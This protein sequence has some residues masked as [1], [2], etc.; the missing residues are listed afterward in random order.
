[1][2]RRPCWTLTLAALGGLAFGPPGPAAADDERARV[3]RVFAAYDKPDSPGCVVGVIRDG[4]LVD[5]RGFG[6]ANLEHAIPLGPRTVLD[7][8][9]TSK[10]FSAAALVLLAQ[11]GRLSLDDEVRKH[12]PE[13][14]DYGRPV[15]IRH[16]LHHTSGLRDYLGLMQLAGWNFEDV[17]TDEDALALIVRQRELNFEPG[18]ERLYSN[19]GFFLV[20]AIV[21]RV[22][23]KSLRAFA[24]ERIFG[25]LGMRDTHFH[26]RHTEIV[27]RRATGYAPRDGGG[28]EIA[29]SNFEQTGDG[30]VYTT[31]EDLL[32]W[33]RNFY[34]G[35]VGGKALVEQLTTPGRLHDGRPL[36]Y[37]LGL[38][39]D[40]HRGLPRVSH[41][42]SWAGY[43]AELMRFPEQR[44]SVACLC[45]L[46]TADPTR[47]ATEVA[48]IHLGGA[49]G[50]EDVP[51]AE[52]R[53]ARPAPSPGEADLRAVAGSYREKASG[54]V[55]RVRFEDGRL[56]VEAFGDTYALTPLGGRRFRL[57][58]G[59]A[60]LTLEFEDGPSGRRLREGA[61]PRP[62]TLWD[63]VQPVAPTAAEMAA[64]AGRYYSEE[65]DATYA[66]EMKDGALALTARRLGGALAPS[67]RDE[68][69]LG[70]M[71]LRF[72][73][74]AQG[75][76]AAFRLGQGR[77]RNLRFARR[78]ES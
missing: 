24:A 16:L 62:V 66:L 25:P 39:V 10:Q 47:L 34:E 9:S 20:S 64:Y 43:R 5:A 68:F 41:G 73:R 58:D 69:T 78:E 61:A 12:V 4:A 42:G 2:P 31:V 33:D 26:D 52:T 23:G 37:G 59:P 72:E 28:F 75:R 53:Y 30:A 60:D 49:L 18:A 70:S 44:L 71:V 77:I 14:P 3:A 51:A 1:M 22:A 56:K 50:P 21:K 8:G 67:V 57:D 15:T 63:A 29:M 35:K 76:P 65:L 55:R 46:A 7:I 6:M 13:L 36:T 45:N 19:S 54:M 74:D 48:E 38:A 32:L 11:D 17:S 27:P 40:Q